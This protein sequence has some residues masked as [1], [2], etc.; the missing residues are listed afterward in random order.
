MRKDHRQ[1]FVVRG[2]SLKESQ[3]NACVCVAAARTRKSLNTSIE[4]AD[5]LLLVLI[6]DTT[7]PKYSTFCAMVRLRN[8]TYVILSAALN[9]TFIDGRATKSTL[10]ERIT[11]CWAVL[12]RS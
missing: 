10:S 12:A 7:L 8:Q 9:K 11:E 2:T 4:L 3:R 6:D 1:L 5:R